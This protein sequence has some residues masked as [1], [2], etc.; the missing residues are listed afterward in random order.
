[1]A[2]NRVEIPEAELERQRDIC[3]NIRE[4]LGGRRPLA[5]VDTY[6]CPLV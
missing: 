2:Y 5:F 3:K 1:M 4:R 6:G